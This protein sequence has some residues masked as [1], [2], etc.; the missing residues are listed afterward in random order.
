MIICYSFRLA[1]K[2]PDLIVNVAESSLSRVS[3]SF[4]MPWTELCLLILASFVR[5]RRT[6]FQKGVFYEWHARARGS[7][8][9]DITRN[10]IAFNSPLTPR[11]L[12]GSP[13]RLENMRKW[14]RARA[15]AWKCRS[16]LSLTRDSKQVLIRFQDLKLRH[17]D[18]PNDRRSHMRYTF[19]YD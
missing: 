8:K 10:L 3:L 9:I 13:S 18:L 5:H 6:C 14:T 15:S 4:S 2:N 11:W 1:K 16:P 7:A 17:F 12:N 19:A